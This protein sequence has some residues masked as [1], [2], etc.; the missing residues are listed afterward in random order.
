MTAE[1]AISIIPARRGDVP[2][3]VAMLADD[4]LGAGRED[5]SVEALPAYEKAFDSIECSSASTLYVALL[6]GRVVGTFQLTFIPGMSRRGGLRADIEAVR[7]DSSVRGKGVGAQ[8]MA[9]ARAKAEGAGAGL[10]QLSSNKVR[11]DAHRFYER[12]GFARSHDGFKLK[13]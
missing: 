12:L 2:A 4:A 13:L 8:M 9:F 3:I 10:L 5:T 11:T 1:R 7:V 6:E